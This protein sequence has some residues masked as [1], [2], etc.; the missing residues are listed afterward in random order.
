VCVVHSTGTAVTS[1]DASAC[2]KASFRS[3]AFHTFRR[4]F[5]NSFSN[6]TINPSLIILSILSC[7]I[8]LSI[9]GSYDLISAT[10]K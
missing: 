5:S 1:S 8:T 10:D 9:D 4:T 6:E 7:T 2:P 3:E